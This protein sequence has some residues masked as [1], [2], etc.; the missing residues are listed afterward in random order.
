[1]RKYDTSFDYSYGSQNATWE[2]WE[3]EVVSI[4]VERLFRLSPD[5]DEEQVTDE[6]EIERFKVFISNSPREVLQKIWE[7]QREY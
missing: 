4:E 2:D 6:R 1:M 3:Y 5:G 7:R